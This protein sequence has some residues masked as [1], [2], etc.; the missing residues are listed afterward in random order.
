M[1]PAQW[2]DLGC[3]MSELAEALNRFSGTM[4]KIEKLQEETVA[5]L[6]RI[7]TIIDL[8]YKHSL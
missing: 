8:A 2:D 7:E 5:S 1:T 6:E 3:A 4:E